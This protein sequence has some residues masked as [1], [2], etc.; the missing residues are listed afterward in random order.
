MKYEQILEDALSRVP[1]TFDKREGS[2]IFDAIAPCCYEL[3]KVYEEIDKKLKNTYAGTADREGL[4]LRAAEINISPNPAT[5]AIRK[6]IF[7]P[8]NIDVLGEVFNLDDLNFTAT[9]KISDGIYQMTCDTL[10]EVGNQGSGM[11]IPINYIDGLED[12]TLTDEVI[13]YGEEEEETETFRKRYFDTLKNEAIDGNVAQY[14]KWCNEYSGIGNCRIFSLWNGANTV[15]V[16]ILNSENGVA[17]QQLIDSF[18]NYLD[19]NSEGLGNGK[20]PIGAIVTVSTAKTKIVNVSCDITLKP[21]YT[22]VINLEEDLNAFFRDSAYV[23]NSVSY[24]SLGSVILENESVDAVENLTLNGSIQDIPLHQEEIG[25]LG[26]I[27]WN[28]V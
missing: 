2:V 6:G 26:E 3:A 21:G 9:A 11:L 16:S 10:G 15:K 19:P 28:T 22:S 27:K 5:Y 13:V 18:Q 12:A 17:S 20:A 24:I 4:I 23:R 8:T 14:T 7:K 25:V 1:D